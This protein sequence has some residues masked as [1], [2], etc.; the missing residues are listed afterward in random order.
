MS[1]ANSAL[2]APVKVGRYELNHRVVLAPLTRFRATTEAV[3]NDL[4]V[5]YYK[6]RTS[7]NGL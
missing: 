2:F 6:Q 4:L 7:E 3:P 5:E 1:A